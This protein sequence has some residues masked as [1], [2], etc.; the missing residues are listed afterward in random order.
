M[1]EADFL[2]ERELDE[3]LPEVSELKGAVVVEWM[4]VEAST[5]AVVEAWMV[6]EASAGT[7]VEAWLVEEASSGAVVVT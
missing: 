5:G 3:G 4:V 7:V 1:E 6:V 2:A